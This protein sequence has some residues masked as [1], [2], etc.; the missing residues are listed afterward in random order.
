MTSELKPCP[1]AKALIAAADEVSACG[2]GNEAEIMRAA[3]KKL[4]ELNTRAVPEVPELVVVSHE[5]FYAPTREWR[6]TSLPDY[7][8][9]NDNLVRDL[10]DKDQAVAVIAAKDLEIEENGKDQD[11]EQWLFWRRKYGAMSQAAS[12]QKGAIHSLIKKAER[13]TKLAETAE[14]KLATCEKERDQWKIRGDNHWD[15][16]RSIRE[17]A[18]EGDCERILLWISDASSGYTD[19]IE[20]TVKSLKDRINSLEAKLAQIEK[21]ESVDGFVISDGVAYVHEQ[22]GAGYYGSR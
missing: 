8:R 18:K 22:Y 3:A 7:Y 2:G 16:I 5:V 14:A 19:G 17:M 9:N 12:N 4:T 11:K 6:K 10:V 15:V 21:Q 1:L 13:L 20:V